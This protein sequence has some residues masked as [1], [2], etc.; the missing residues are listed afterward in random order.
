V[1]SPFRGGGIACLGDPDSYA[2]WSFIL[3]IYLRH[4]MYKT[5][6]FEEK[7]QIFEMNSIRSERHTLNVHLIRE[8]ERE[9]ERGF[10]SNQRK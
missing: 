4:E 1:L 10:T 7:Y 6:L 5:C 9:R 8:R 3:L 2:D